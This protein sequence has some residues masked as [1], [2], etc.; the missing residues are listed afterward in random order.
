MK[1]AFVIILPLALITSFILIVTSCISDKKPVDTEADF[2]GF[3]TEINSSQSEGISGRI[4]VESHADKIVTK[5][6]VTIKKDTLIFKQDGD[7]LHNATFSALETKQWVRI[8]FSGPIM[9][10]WPM[11][12]TAKQ[13]VIVEYAALID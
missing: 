13:V 11:Q 5:Y 8:W 1:K 4:S 3:I 6:I 10:S 2:I 9:E 7:N 12:G